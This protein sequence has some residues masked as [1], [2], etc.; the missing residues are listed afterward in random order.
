MPK[1]DQNITAMSK[2]LDVP[3]GT[4]RNRFLGKTL[5]AKESQTNKMLLSPAQEQ[6]LSEWISQQHTTN[7]IAGPSTGTYSVQT[8]N[9]SF[10]Q[11]FNKSAPLYQF[12]SYS[13]S[14]FDTHPAYQDYNDH[15]NGYAMTPQ[16]E[17][18]SFYNH[19]Y[20]YTD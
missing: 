7:T 11:Y 12:D 8:P 10:S 9:Q 19:N 17:D 6:A 20:N 2:K 4:L 13:A 15:L 3:Y 5:P 14:H 1:A 16:Y 18:S